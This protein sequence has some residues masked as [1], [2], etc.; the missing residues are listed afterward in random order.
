MLEEQT[1]LRIFEGYRFG[2]QVE[3]VRTTLRTG[4]IVLAL[5]VDTVSAHRT[6]KVEAKDIHP[7]VLT[8]TANQGFVDENSPVGTLVRDNNSNPITFAVSDKDLD[9][10]IF[11]CSQLFSF[12]KL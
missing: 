3:D 6:I 7:P 4:L 8:V 10:V 5:V 1:D 9:S 11:K 2:A 12:I